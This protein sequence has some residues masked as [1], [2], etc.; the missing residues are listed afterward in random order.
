MI[1]FWCND[2]R[3]RK[4]RRLP[5]FRTLMRILVFKKAMI[6]LGIHPTILCRAMCN[7]KSKQAS[8]NFKYNWSREMMLK[9]AKKIDLCHILLI[10]E[11]LVYT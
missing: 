8:F 5:E 10:T 4:C 2:Y 11:V 6:N 7:Y 9:S 3:R 1:G